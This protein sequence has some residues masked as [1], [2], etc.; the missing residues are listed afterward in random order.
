M[1]H[2]GLT[3]ARAL[4]TAPAVRS[5]PVMR[6]PRLPSNRLPTPGRGMGRPG[7]VLGVRLPGR[8][9]GVVVGYPQPESPSVVSVMVP[10][11]TFGRVPAYGV[12]VVSGAPQ[13]ESCGVT[14]RSTVRVIPVAAS[15]VRA[16]AAVKRPRL[17]F[18]DCAFL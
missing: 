10:V 3:V 16:R 4:G 2:A 8:Y 9:V 12:L 5:G 13:P 11:S 7:R 15:A 18:T 1:W 6:A 14:V 17:L